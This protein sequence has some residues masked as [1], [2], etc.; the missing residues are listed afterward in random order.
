MV[1]VDVSG[2]DAPSIVTDDVDGARALGIGAAAQ[3]G[4]NLTGLVLAGILT[5]AVQSRLTT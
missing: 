2:V 4:V 5:L 3:L 1:L